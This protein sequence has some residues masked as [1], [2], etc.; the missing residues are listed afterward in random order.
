MWHCHCCGLGSIPGPGTS[1][2]LG[3][4][5]ILKYF[6]KKKKTLTA[7]QR[8]DWRGVRP[9]IGRLVVVE[10]QAKIRPI[11]SKAEMT[12]MCID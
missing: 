2:C 8:I 9:V 6:K 10:V 11:R 3:H 1:T 5:Q 12:T 4:G 7:I